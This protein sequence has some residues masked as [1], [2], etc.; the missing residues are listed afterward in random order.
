MK[1]KPSVDTSV[2][3]REFE[4]YLA[5]RFIRTAHLLHDRLYSAIDER[6]LTAKH[7]GV[8]KLLMGRGPLRQTEIAE[9]T[10]GDRT[11]AM[12]L[13]DQLEKVGY[14]ERRRDPSDRRAHAVTVTQ[15]G[16]DWLEAVEPRVRAAEKSFLEPLDGH[17]Q[18][19]LHA[20]LGKLLAAHW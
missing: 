18:A 3:P 13:V 10:R 1:P 6:G 20:L 14:V 11:T 4:G 5:F 7:M 2:L 12:L 17:E 19:Q 9:I 16:R 8:I 15:A